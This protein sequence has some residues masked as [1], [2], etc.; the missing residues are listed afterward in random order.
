MKVEEY[1]TL[2]QKEF[3]S[4][5]ELKKLTRLLIKSHEPEGS[6]LHLYNISPSDII[7]GVLCP[8]C[9]QFHMERFSKSWHCP[10]CGA[11][12]S[13]AHEQAVQDYFLLVSPTITNKQLRSFLLLPSQKKASYLLSKMDL[14]FTGITKNRIYFNA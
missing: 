7:P 14:Q 1:Q 11:D 2:H 6:H 3:L 9:N 8:D 10:S 13:N 5:K 4:V 12:S